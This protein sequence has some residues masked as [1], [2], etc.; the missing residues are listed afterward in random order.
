MRLL[1]VIDS[2]APGGAETSLVA[3][4]PGLIARGIDLHVLPLGNAVDLAPALT[5]AGA[6]LHRRTERPGRVGNLRAVLRVARRV[7]PDLVHTTLFEADLAGRTA[8]R[9]LGIRA[10]TSLVNEYYSSSHASESPALKLRLARALD[11]FTAR[12][13]TRFHAVAGAVADSVGPVLGVTGDRLIVIPRG[14]EPERFP[15]QPAGL[16]RQTRES[17]GLGPETPVVL[18]VGRLEPQKGFQHLLKAVPLIAGAVPDAVVLVAGRDGRAAETLRAQAAGLPL[19]V[20]FLGH[21]TDMPALMAAADVL[22]FPSEREGSPG[23]LI[24]AMAV[25]VPIVASDIAPCLEVL[26]GNNPEVALVTP[27]GDPKALRDA[28]VAALTDRAAAQQRAVAARDRFDR[29]YT[30]DSVASQMSDF[31]VRAAEEGNR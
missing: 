16:R 12:F 25:G 19:E 20:R 23:T 1:Y 22:A 27:I 26:G 10:S 2:L 8:A 3:M 24:E 21:R 15:F 9:L 13:A 28:V 30:I 4:A 18:G 5:D 11:R 6:I 14:R 31:F 7:R 17:L 29:L